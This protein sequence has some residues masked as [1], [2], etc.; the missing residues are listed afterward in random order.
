MSE[1]ELQELYI[2]IKPELDK[3]GIGYDAFALGISI[4]E[5]IGNENEED[6]DKLANFIRNPK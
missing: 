5:C 3:K 6:A 1:Q 2:I 4:I